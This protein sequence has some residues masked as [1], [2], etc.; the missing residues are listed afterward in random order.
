MLQ[1][2]RRVASDLAAEGVDPA[3]D[4]TMADRLALCALSLAVDIEASRR[5]GVA[6]C[7][8]ARDMLAT[9][10]TEIEATVVHPLRVA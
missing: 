9:A 7:P 4:L 8:N 5:A 2:G 6:P 1:A 10:L 3:A